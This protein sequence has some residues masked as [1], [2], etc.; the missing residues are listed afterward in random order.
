MRR[1]HVRERIRHARARELGAHR[2]PLHLT[3]ESSRCGAGEGTQ[4]P[5]DEIPAITSHESASPFGSAQARPP[6]RPVHG[7]TRPARRCAADIVGFCSIRLSVALTSRPPRRTAAASDAR[8]RGGRFPRAQPE[9]QR[10]AER[11]QQ[12]TP[13]PVA[14]RPGRLRER[15]RLHRARRFGA[16]PRHVRAPRPPPRSDRRWSRLPPRS[17]VAPPSTVYRRGP[18][19]GQM[20]VGAVAHV[21][22]AT[23]ADCGLRQPTEPPAAS[24]QRARRADRSP[25]RRA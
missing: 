14:Q 10:T 12:A 2:P 17:R 4:C 15:L 16:R 22:H 9:E 18:R 19:A 11:A 20:T 1:N 5:A 24:G 3:E 23:C 8:R 13:H 6:E 25:L 21:P 7:L